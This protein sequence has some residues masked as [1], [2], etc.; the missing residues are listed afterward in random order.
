MDFHETQRKYRLKKFKFFVS[1]LLKLS[2]LIL[3][4]IIGWRIGASDNDILLLEN[5][6]LS[7]SL[8]LLKQT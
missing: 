1:I 2:V 4:L 6:K 3:T 7:K 8:K 5:E